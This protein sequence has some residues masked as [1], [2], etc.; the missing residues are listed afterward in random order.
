MVDSSVWIDYLSLRISPVDQ[1][2]E[3]LIHTNNQAVITC[4]VFQEILQGAK[5]QKSYELTKRLLGRLP[6]IFPTSQTHQRA[7]ELFRKLVS[8]RKTPTTVDV[9]IAALAI[10]KRIPLFTLD[11]DFK[12]IQ[13]YCELQ[14]FN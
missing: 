12:S 10:E 6:M 7:A 4:I 13:A 9:L 2:L 11:A 8:A 14:L 3:A 5:N 1:K